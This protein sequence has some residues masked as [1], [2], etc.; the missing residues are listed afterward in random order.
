LQLL[1][2]TEQRVLRLI[3]GGLNN[4]EIALATGVQVKTVK[5]HVSNILSKLDVRS[6]VE[7]A[8]IGQKYLIDVVTDLAAPMTDFESTGT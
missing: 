2:P 5:Y 4:K 7:A 1:S 3:V 8:L 6:R